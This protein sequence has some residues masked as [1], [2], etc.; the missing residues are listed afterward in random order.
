MTLK[1]TFKIALRGLGTN[2]SRSLLTILGVVIGI[3]AIILVM[4]V[5][6]AAQNLILGQI[7]AIGSR[8]IAIV[9]GRQPKG[10]TDIIT[11][12]TDSLKNRDLSALE[13]KNNVPR[14]SGIMPVVFGSEPAVYSSDT[15]RP[16]IFGVTPLFL[17][18][19]NIY[20][21]DGR[22][23]TDD[24][25]QSYGAVVVIG[26]KVKDEL[27]GNTYPVGE[28]IK[29]KGKNFTVIGILG[30][31]G[32]SSFINFDEMAIIPYT[33]AQEYIFG[34]KYFQR[35]VVEADTEANVPS[36]VED[37]KLTLR[38]AHNITDP[39]KDDFF[40]ETQAQAMD[41]VRTV[42]TIFTL[43]LGSV[44]A[45]S[46]VVG[47]I[48]IMNIMLVSVSERTHEIG[49]RKAI[50][51][52]DKDI[53]G[54]FLLEAVILTVLGGVVGIIFG[55]M[56]SFLT[57]FVLSRAIASGWGFAF[58]ISGALLGFGVAAFVGLVFGLYPARQAA[59]KSP[60]EALRY[61]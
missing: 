34:I 15:Y 53:M 12:F 1:D 16:T 26:S 20:P 17:D 2:R 32:Q 45:I 40:V 10:P 18:I 55:A 29:I 36:T 22:M 37:I 33:T 58:P 54:Q 57:A 46:L 56:L 23:F 48:G 24:E 30:S 43:F 51:A 14:L 4:S 3:T 60:I 44:A 31:K 25:V 21:S 39:A 9:P 19:Y 59:K 61:E 50:G 41:I 7:Q 8:T 6:Q 49:L 35:I 28:K 11:M 47:G 27:F 5:G 13:N 52:T 42:M 38:N